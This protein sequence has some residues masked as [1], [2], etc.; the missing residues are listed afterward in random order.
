MF[1]K[2]AVGIIVLGLCTASMT[3][4]AVLSGQSSEHP[5]GIWIIILTA[6]CMTVGEV[7]FSPLGNAFISKYSPKKLLGTMLGVWPVSYTHLDVYKR[8]VSNSAGIRSAGRH[9][10]ISASSPNTFFF[11][12]SLNGFTVAPYLPLNTSFVS[13]V[14]IL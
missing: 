5:V 12:S 7:I 9:V 2:T 3:L 8:Q 11:T 6:V 4:A 13:F 10:M 14:A 1:T